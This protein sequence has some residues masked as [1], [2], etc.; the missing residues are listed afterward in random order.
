M[1]RLKGLAFAALLTVGILEAGLAGAGPYSDDLAKCMVRTSTPADRAEFVR[2]LFSAMAQH[3]DVSSMANISPQQMEA[4]LKGTGELIQRLLLES[5]RSEAQQAIHYEGMQSV[6]F[7]FQFYGQAMAAELL[8]NPIVAGKMK[9]LNKYL[10]ADRFK[11]FAA[12]SAAGQDSGGA[13]TGSRGRAAGAA[14][15]AAPPAPPPK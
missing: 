6:F 1:P 9:D 7:G 2:F 5:C 15:G 11:A 10:D 8:G 13:G 4:T 3:P 14:G 12:E